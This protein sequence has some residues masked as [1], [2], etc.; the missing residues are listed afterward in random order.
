MKL[1]SAIEY[2]YTKNLKIAG[3]FYIA[4]AVLLGI[5]IF[6]I[7]LYPNDINANGGWDMAY[8]ITAVISLFLGVLSFR[9]EQ[10]FFIQNGSTREQ[11]HLSFIAFLP[12][13]IVFSLAERLLTFIF[14]TAVKTD[15]THFLTTRFYVEH[16]AF[17]LDVIFETL[18][19][20][21]FLSF[22]YLIGII[23]YRVKPTYRI[24]GIIVIVFFFIADYSICEMKNVL[25]GFT[26]MPQL[27]FYGSAHGELVP[28][29][30]VLSHI[31]TIC[32]LLSLSHI[33]SSGTN[34]NGKEKH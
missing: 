32:A 5:I 28:M 14:C 25:P 15:Y 20:M 1:K 27:L 33:L 7:R 34:V 11:S 9:D 10:K 2:R 31:L 24:L 23:N 4:L 8:Y 6:A 17:W 19:F 26:Y 21:C 16:R 12:V 30:F 3:I 18:A 22:G 29:N 13:G